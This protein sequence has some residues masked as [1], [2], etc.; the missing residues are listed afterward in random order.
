MNIKKLELMPKLPAKKRVCAYARVSADKETALHSLSHQISY[1]SEYIQKH[2]GWA[3]V[4]VYSDEGISGTRDTRPGFAKMI[5]DAKS[6]KIDLILTKSI[7]RFARNTVTLLSSV[8]ELKEYGVDVFFEEQNIHSISGDGELMLTLLA[9]FAQEEAKSVSENMRWRIMKVFEEG[10]N[11]SLQVLGYDLKDGKLFINK[12][13]EPIIK[14]IFDSYLDGKGYQAIAHSLNKKGYKTKV[15]KPF[16]QTS[17]SRILRNVIYMGDLNLE[18][19]YREELT[20][21]MIKNEGQFDRFYVENAHKA[22]IPKEKFLKVQTEIERRCAEAPKK[23]PNGTPFTG[24]IVCGLDGCNFIR[25]NTGTRPC[26]KCSRYKKG[27]PALCD[28]RQ[29]GESELYEAINQIMDESSF[30]ERIKQ[31]IVYPD[32]KLKFLFKDGEE[33]ETGYRERSRKESWTT[34]MKKAAGERTRAQHTKMK[35]EE[36]HGKGNKN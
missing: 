10:R 29:L 19:R 31:I 14:E 5:E 22:I 7:S 3:Y 11:Y 9:S 20:K 2:K 24:L 27:G 18:K 17:I 16:Q 13:E 21:R 36:K 35:K 8:R 4:G 33:I 26:W 1:Y 6:G 12:K 32:F 34:E 23:H 30:F 28:S 15:G 25:C